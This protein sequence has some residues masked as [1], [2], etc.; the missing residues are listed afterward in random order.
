MSDTPTSKDVWPPEQRS[1]P[2]T[3]NAYI[4]YAAIYG[5]QS[6]NA[7]ILVAPSMGDLKEAALRHSLGLDTEQVKRVAVFNADHT[8]REQS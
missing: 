3:H 7:L 1:V 4:G 6:D 2:E 8:E 5:R